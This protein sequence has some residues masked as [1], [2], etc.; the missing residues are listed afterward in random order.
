MTLLGLAPWQAL[1]LFAAAIAATWWVFVR[2]VRPPRVSVPSM[3]LWR[4]VL[5]DPRAMTWWERIRKAVSLALALVVAGALAI[6]IANPAPKASSS[7]QGR[8]VIVLDSS[9]S[10]R[11]PVPGGGTRWSRAIAGARDLVASS[12]GEVLIA[13]TSEGLV[14]G[15]TTDTALL[16][17]ALDR[18]VPT[19]GDGTAWPA[20]AAAGSVHFFTDG[21]RQRPLASSVVVQSV[22]ESAD[23]VGI[24][25]FALR[26]ATSESGQ[27][28]AYL[29]IGNF[30]GAQTVQLTLSRGKTV[31][32]DRPIK[33]DAGK[34][35]RESIPFDIAGD[36]VFHAHI[37]APS[38]AMA[39]DDDAVAWVTDASPIDVTIV[40]AQ[41]APF[42]HL[43]DHAPG[44]SLHVAAPNAYPSGHEDVAIF[45]HWLPST[46]PTT[47]A[48]VIDPPPTPWLGTQGSPEVAPKWTG[49]SD[50]PALAQPLLVGLDALTLTIAAA[51]GVT[52][53]SLVP[54]AKSERGTAL[55]SVVDRQDERLVVLAF[56]PTDSNLPLA[57]A[58]PVLIGNAVEWLGRGDA[59]AARA[60]GPVRLPSSV[61]QV[62][63]P[64]D[65]PLRLT[66]FGDSVV[67][68]LA[69]PG[70]YTIDA[71]GARRHVAV[72]AGDAITSNLAHAPAPTAA[73]TVATHGSLSF[74]I[75][76][77]L[78]VVACVLA[79]VEW[80]TWQRRITV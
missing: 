6:A 39:D 34:I 20:V 60:P 64:D 3:L 51:R 14:E 23:N 72:N 31:V 24:T 37:A 67:A 36:P 50:A 62:I 57:P 77:L 70:L 43:F 13:T 55:V 19:G 56:G 17:S 40:S 75:W 44:V 16:D 12:S 33:L 22:F 46:A 68:T 8:T 26:P 18:L 32:L 1:L 9:W 41:P 61:R 5:D 49:A 66:R 2:K 48:L 21:Q 63:G 47:P 53:D 45:D 30:A 25:A 79:G 52:S 58:F 28:S 15:P 59:M 69:R 80:L 35:E 27:P 74:P 71:G 11:A 38:N 4:A 73:V 54:V 29:E 76:F 65:K 10:M 42:A 7:L 78:V